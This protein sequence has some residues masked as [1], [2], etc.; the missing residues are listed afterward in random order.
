MALTNEDLQ[1]IAGLLQPIKDD[2]HTLK[3]E[4]VIMRKELEAKIE[5]TEHTL[6]DDFQVQIQS[7]RTDLQE[8]IQ[9]VRTDLQEQIQQ[10]EQKLRK[11][12]H[13]QAQKT[14][15]YIKKEI[16]SSE[17]LVLEEVSRV[18]HILEKHINDE[19]RHTA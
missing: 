3:K 5:H 16:R 7:V 14:K 13:V 15:Q 2:V 9:T 8:Q 10:T 12:I 1:A 18:H 19:T 4:Q 17:N 11:E 6:R